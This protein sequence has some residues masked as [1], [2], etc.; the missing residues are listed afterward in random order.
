MW[1]KFAYT[2]ADGKVY[3]VDY[4]NLPDSVITKMGKTRALDG[5]QTAK[6]DGVE[7][8]WTYHPDDGLEIIYSLT[9]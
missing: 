2:A 6:G 3:N 4:Y 1:A 5:V 7:I 9:D 8:S